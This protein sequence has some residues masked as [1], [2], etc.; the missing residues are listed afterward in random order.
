MPKTE[1]E[2]KE[3]FLAR[4]KQLSRTNAQMV[5]IYKDVS[6]YVEAHDIRLKEYQVCVEAVLQALVS[7][8]ESSDKQKLNA[9]KDLMQNCHQG[10]IDNIFQAPGADLDQE[11]A[12]S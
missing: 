11:Y 5:S 6:A 2:S 3:N 4:L 12:V 7:D 9:I 10:T 8:K 1:L